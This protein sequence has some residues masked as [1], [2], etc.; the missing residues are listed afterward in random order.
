MN[1][2]VLQPEV[3]ALGE[4][5]E[6]DAEAACGPRHGR[7]PARKAHRCGKTKG[8]L[9]FHGG[10]VE[11]DRPRVRGFDGREQ[12]LATW[13][14]ASRKDLLGNWAMNQMLID[15]STRKFGRSVRLPEGD[16]TAGKG[17]GVSKSA[18]SRRFVACRRQSCRSS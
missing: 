6:R 11:T 1:N 10:K 7:S 5:L 17:A 3:E 8:K 13:E 18:V 12:A 16:I 9:G 15:V 2:C 4:M 14:E